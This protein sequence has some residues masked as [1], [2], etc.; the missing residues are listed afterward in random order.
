MCCAIRQCIYNVCLYTPRIYVLYSVYKYV[1]GCTVQCMYCMHI[2]PL[3]QYSMHVCTCVH[4]HSM[5]MFNAVC[6]YMLNVCVFYAV[7]THIC[8][9][10]LRVCSRHMCACTLYRIQCVVSIYHTQIHIVCGGTHCVHGTM[11]AHMFM[12]RIHLLMS[13]YVCVCVSRHPDQTG[14]SDRGS[15]IGND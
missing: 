8:T 7:C 6:T 9:F 3:H 15:H 1:L 11:C 5:C 4:I 13:V 12:L 10:T 14:L 2:I